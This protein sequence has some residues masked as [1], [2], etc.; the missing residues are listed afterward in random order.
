M[1]VRCFNCQVTWIL[2]ALGGCGGGYFLYFLGGGVLLGLWDYAFCNPTLGWTSKIPAPSQTHQVSVPILD[3]NSLISVAY[4][5][6][7][8]L[9]IIPFSVANAHVI[10]C[11]STPTPGCK[12]SSRFICVKWSDFIGDTADHVGFVLET[13]KIKQWCI[14]RLH[15]K[16]FLLDQLY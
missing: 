8:C 1:S 16:P 6:R 15:N 2:V 5:R 7:S 4:P 11:G 9:K 12:A 3:Q 10:I 14:I 13:V